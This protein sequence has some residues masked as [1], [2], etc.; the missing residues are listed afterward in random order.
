V[1]EQVHSRNVVS[2]PVRG[3]DGSC[4][5]WVRLDR[6]R[7]GHANQTE[8]CITIDVTGY[9]SPSEVRALAERLVDVAS[10]AEIHLVARHRS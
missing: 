2:L 5:G 7:I 4:R 6:D 1:T 3:D 10:A 9:L 8:F